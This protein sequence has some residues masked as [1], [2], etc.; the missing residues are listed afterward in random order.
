MVAEA[1]SAVIGGGGENWQY[2]DIDAD[3]SLATRVRIHDC[4][5]A[6]AVSHRSE[7]MCMFFTG[8]LRSSTYSPASSNA[9]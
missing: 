4:L 9:G 3:A 1:A 2:I 6:A 5:V 8:M 7:R